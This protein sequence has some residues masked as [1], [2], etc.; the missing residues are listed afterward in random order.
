MIVV[1]EVLKK[2]DQE[3]MSGRWRLFGPAAASATPVSDYIRQSG[4]PLF[5]TYRSQRSDN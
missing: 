2:K 1:A 4:V 3:R 5:L